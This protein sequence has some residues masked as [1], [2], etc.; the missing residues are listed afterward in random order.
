MKKYE[1]MYIVRTTISDDEVKAV[2][3]EMEDILTNN[4]AKIIEVEDKGQREL[5]YEIKNS[6]IELTIAII[7]D[8][9]DTLGKKMAKLK[10]KLIEYCLCFVAIDGERTSDSH[11]MSWHRCWNITPSREGV[12]LFSRCRFWGNC[13]SIIN[14][15]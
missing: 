13:R 1:I 5:A 9:V 2:T 7:D 14:L 6:D 15:V 3:K 10:D 11:I 4:G 8:F 12:T